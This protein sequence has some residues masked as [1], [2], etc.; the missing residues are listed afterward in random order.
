[1]RSSRLIA[2]FFA[3]AIVAG[4]F[5]GA[6]YFIAMDSEEAATPRPVPALESDLDDTVA[7]DDRALAPRETAS[8][9]DPAAG[10]DNGPGTAHK[11]D[12]GPETTDPAPSGAHKDADPKADGETDGP[13]TDQPGPSVEDR[14]KQQLA[15]LEEAGLD[16]DSVM[17]ARKADFE[18]TISGQVVDTQGTPVAGAAVKA[19][20]SEGFSQDRGGRSV[21]FVM[22]DESGE[23]ETI[24]TTDGGGYWTAGINRKVRERAA[25]TVRLTASAATFADS[26]E[27]S[28]SLKNGDSREGIKLTLRGAGSVTGR[29]VDAHGVGVA[30]VTV[31][32]NTSQ[33]SL[34]GG[35]VVFELPG[36]ARH[37]AMTDLAGEFLIE[38]V[39]EGRY[40]FQLTATGYRQTSG[41]TAIDVKAGQV[42]SAPADFTVAPTGSIT[43]TLLDAEGNPPAGWVSVNVKNNEGRVIKR[44]NGPIGD[45]GRFER[46]DPPPGTFEVEFNVRGYKAVTRTV[47]FIENQNYDFGT[48]IL[49]PEQPAGE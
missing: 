17:G 36:G 24:A 14:I 13:R 16:I 49:E 41:P 40:Q 9:Q 26:E 47:T 4:I 34:G 33:D 6:G 10:P 35:R 25:L 27:A 11:P 29:V 20:F 15:K 7:R 37:A 30:G 3:L 23:G 48:L 44:M 8:G 31:S 32:L 42:H 21:R 38:G 28:V 2:G 43:A 39:P 45:G 46:N 22:D 18:A 1:M 19:R 5:F 12:A